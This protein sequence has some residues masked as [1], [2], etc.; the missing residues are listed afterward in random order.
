[1][2]VIIECFP[3]PVSIHLFARANAHF[4][5]FVLAASWA[6]A[7]LNMRTVKFRETLMKIF[8]VQNMPSP[9]SPQDNHFRFAFA[10]I[11]LPECLPGGI[12]MCYRGKKSGE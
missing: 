2:E 8:R 5:T 1:V 4:Y 11:C 9:P 6:W 12:R 10:L 7:A 3:G